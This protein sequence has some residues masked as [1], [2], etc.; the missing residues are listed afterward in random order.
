[1]FVF[2]VPV[3]VMEVTIPSCM[4]YHLDQLPISPIFNQ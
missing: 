1:V 2:L 4:K 3:N